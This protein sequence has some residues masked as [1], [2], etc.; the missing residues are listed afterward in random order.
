MPPPSRVE[1]DRVSGPPLS[2][3]ETAAGGEA[4]KAK[5]RRNKLIAR[6]AELHETG[7]TSKKTVRE[8]AEVD[9]ELNLLGPHIERLDERAE[10]QYR[11]ARVNWAKEQA[12]KLVAYTRKLDSEQSAAWRDALEAKDEL[13][14]RSEQPLRAPNLSQGA[15]A[16]VQ[17]FAW[18]Y[19]LDMPDM[20]TLRHG[21][22]IEA[23]HGI[24]YSLRAIAEDDSAW[25]RLALNLKRIEDEDEFERRL[26]EVLE[27]FD[28]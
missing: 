16:V 23:L 21:P 25:L 24:R 5:D 7:D 2:P 22:E 8:L 4:R 3:A 20:P 9:A 19:G 6:K 14:R 12:G 27:V 11:D 17:A 18:H 13:L 15:Q 10:A 26:A 1:A 28:D